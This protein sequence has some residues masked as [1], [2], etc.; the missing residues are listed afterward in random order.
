MSKK[1]TTSTDPKSGTPKPTMDAPANK[2]NKGP[3]PKV[4][5]NASR[6]KRATPK[7]PDP[8]KGY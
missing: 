1:P 5:P 2:R 3:A 8:T 4:G 7:A 6:G